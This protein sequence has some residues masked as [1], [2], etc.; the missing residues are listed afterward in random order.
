MQIRKDNQGKWLEADY[1]KYLTQT[2]ATEDK[3]R[4]LVNRVYTYNKNK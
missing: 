4:L 1:D 2:S 3:N